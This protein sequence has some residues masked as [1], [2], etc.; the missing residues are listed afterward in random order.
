VNGRPAV[1]YLHTNVGLANGIAHLSCAQRAGTPLVILNGMKSTVIANRDG[2]TTVPHPT[3][4]VRQHV[5]FE[6]IALRADGLADDLMR[7]LKA[8]RSEPAGPVYLGLP[9]DLIEAEGIVNVADPARHAV[10]ARRRP[11]PE[12]VAAAA[13]ALAAGR[14]VTIVVGG[15]EVARSGAHDALVALADRLDAAVVL[16]DRRTIETIV[17]GGVDASRFAGFYDPRNPAIAEADVILFAGMPAFME[18]DVPRGPAVPSEATIVHLHSDPAQIAKVAP[19]D[20]ALVGNARLALSDVAD[21]LPAQLDGTSRAAFRARAIA[22]YR[23]SDVV[24]RARAHGRANETPIAVDALC[25]ALHDLLARDAIVVA[26]AVTSSLDL[27]ELTLAGSERTCYTTAGGSLGW[28]MGGAVGVALG[29]P[30]RRIYSV[31]GDGVFQ[32]GLQALFTAAQLALPITTIVIDN[33]SYGAVK[34]AVK[35]YRGGAL[36]ESWVASDLSGIDIATIARGFG[37]FATTVSELRE[38]EAALGEADAQPGP[39][40]VVV[41]TDPHHTGP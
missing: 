10:D 17:A 23:E 6:R 26:D 36:P 39:S 18:F 22:A 32:F 1:A 27:L 19:A 9:Q 31:I 8:V 12:S 16:E 11:D 30:G 28:A 3:D 33:R 34:A 4:Y 15:N 7:T 20:I 24:R 13:R 35:R 40:V 29:T 25:A 2:F 41:R 38:L 5:V 14:A 37:A 21:A